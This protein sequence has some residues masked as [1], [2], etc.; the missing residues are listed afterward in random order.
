MH[1]CILYR[2]RDPRPSRAPPP[3]AIIHSRMFQ[4]DA[5]SYTSAAHVKYHTVMAVI[6][7]RATCTPRRGSRLGVDK[8]PKVKAS[9]KICEFFL[10][11]AVF[12]QC[13]L[14][15]DT[16]SSAHLASG[17]PLVLPPS[18]PGHSTDLCVH[19]LLLYLAT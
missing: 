5:P 16:I 8:A 12:S 17:R 6:S 15:T 1:D 9:A 10:S 3:H 14:V 19:L 2:H 7:D 11:L 18:G 4:K 13:L